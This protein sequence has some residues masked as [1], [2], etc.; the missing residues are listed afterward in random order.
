MSLTRAV[1]YFV[2]TLSLL[3][4]GCS[5]NQSALT[6]FNGPTMGTNY[7][8]KI[9]SLPETIKPAKLHA[10]IN[11]RLKA[12]NQLFSTYDNDS[13]LSKLNQYYG[14]EPQAVSDELITVLQTAQWIFELS[15]GAFDVTVGPLV[16]LWGFGPGAQ[17]QHV[18]NTEEIARAQNQVGM[19][20]LNIDGEAGTVQKHQAEL[21]IDLSAIA[22]GYAVDALA[23]MLDNKAI[24]HYMIDIGGELRT[25]G[26]NPNQQPWQIAIEKPSQ[27][28]RNVYTVIAP[29]S[30]SVATSGDYRNYFEHDGQQYSHTIDPR[31]G[32]PVQ[33]N[34]ASVTVIA[35]NCMLADALATALLVL[36]PEAGYALA[37]EQQL[38]ALF[39][40][41]HNDGFTDKPTPAF[42]RYLTDVTRSQE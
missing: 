37:T 23:T 25:K 30:Q 33:H 34:L 19:T 16:N 9:V 27:T 39:I 41:K 14:T 28:S 29:E 5:S 7:Q 12:L 22:K 3:L 20:L 24:D 35:D 38:A 11:A 31:T 18:P 36:G 15:Q 4:L 42:T 17:T 6:E 26:L 21:Y 8:V 10:E 13:E 32:W 2:F 40:I 1:H